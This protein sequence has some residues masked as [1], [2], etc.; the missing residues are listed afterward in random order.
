MSWAEAE[1]SSTSLPD[2]RL[3]RRLARVLEQLSAK[4]TQSIPAASGSWADT[5]AAYRFFDN[6]RVEAVDILDGHTRSTLQRIEGE[7]VVLLLQDTTFLSYLKDIG[8]HDFGTLRLKTR[9]EHLLHPSVAFT[10]ERV[11]LGVLGHQFWQRPKKAVGHRRKQRPIEQKESVRWLLGYE[12]ACAVQALNPEALVVNIADREGD[13]HEWFL[14]GGLDDVCPDRAGYLIRAK[15]NRRVA[16]GKK[17]SYL[18]ETLSQAPVLGQTAV[19]ITARPGR[20]ARVAKLSVRSQAVTFNRARRPGGQLPPVT[21]TAIYAKEAR[22]PAGEKAL[23]WMLL[24]NLPVEDFE[25]AEQLISWYQARWE[26]ELYFRIVKQ[27]CR[28]EQLRLETAERLERCIAVYLIVAWRLHY[29]TQIARSMAQAPCTQAF[30]DQEWQ[31][32]Y[33]LHMKRP[34]PEKPPTM[35]ETVR[36]LAQ[37]GGFLARKGDGE[38]GSETLWRGYMVLQQSITALE[39]AATVGRRQ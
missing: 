33:L 30:S 31:T 9:E 39:I 7:P 3:K 12:M 19:S 28:I 27:G 8:E 18:W 13:I 1:A 38:P 32:I 17:N 16:K 35:R 5:K 2:P 26:I 10:G 21:V 6:D 25:A 36:M 11:N 37:L 29:L 24:T 22:P 15:C 20:R 4:P 34:P 23:E 14:D